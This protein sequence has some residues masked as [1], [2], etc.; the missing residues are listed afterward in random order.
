MT[1]TIFMIIVVTGYFLD[2]LPMYKLDAA[3]FEAK[4]IRGLLPAKERF[5]MA[6]AFFVVETILFV[7]ACSLF[8]LK[9]L[10]VIPW[11]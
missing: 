7:V 11:W 4:R 3:R 2:G 1:S 5:V 10:G 8:L 6:K 9:C